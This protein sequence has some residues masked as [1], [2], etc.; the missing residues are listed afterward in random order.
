MDEI[1]QKR[2]WVGITGLCNN[3]CVF[4]L[5]AG[6]ER[7]GFRGFEEVRKE[8]SDGL[9]DGCERL[10]LSG[11]EA[12]I[13]PSFISFI[14]LGKELGYQRIQTITNGRMFSS[15]AFILRTERAG[16]DEITFSIHGHVRALH[17]SLTR[18][19]G[20]FDQAVRG[21]RNALSRKF[22]VNADIVLSR[23]NVH[24]FRDILSFLSDTGI[25]EFDI[26]FLVPFGNAWKDRHSLM[27]DPSERLEDLR[28][29]FDF[30][31]RQGLVLWTNRFPPESL[32]G[33]ERLIQDPKKLVDEVYG[34]KKDFSLLLENG[35]RLDCAGERCSYCRLE[36]FC[37][38]L[39]SLPE[40]QDPPSNLL[41]VRE[42]ENTFDLDRGRGRLTIIPASP[43]GADGLI[44][45]PSRETIRKLISSLDQRE[46]LSIQGI[47]FCFLPSMYR[48]LVYNRG[49]HGSPGGK[50]IMI[51]ASQYFLDHK[52]KA[53]S[54]RE[55]CY[56]HECDG[57]F[58]SHIKAKGFS[59][60]GPPIMK[61][62]PAHEPPKVPDGEVIL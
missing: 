34:R 23:R 51:L 50:G 62:A 61:A 11:G 18:V 47:P 25:R 29:G 41:L 37:R 57:Y 53:L 31:E 59:I 12:S 1:S 55:C 43:S 36:G 8:I 20:S 22:I 56:Y 26:L 39:E 19:D 24:Y 17:D 54:C 33:Y 28:A 15:K 5:D 35:V 9:A 7:P 13:H 38:H 52:A 10:I 30:A 60:L 27:F 49:W 2:K 42:G 46:I 48:N 58:T 14:Q 3:N 40:K 4:C 21:I 6:R 45:V 16:L 32:E 44:G